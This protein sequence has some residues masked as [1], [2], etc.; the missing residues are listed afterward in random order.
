VFIDPP[1]ESALFEPAIK[2]A[3][4]SIKLNGWIYLEAP[5]KWDDV[6]LSTLGLHTYR[7][8]KAGNVNAHLLQRIA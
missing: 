8:L 7:Y 4:Q 5:K 2:A 3:A 1:F 6:E